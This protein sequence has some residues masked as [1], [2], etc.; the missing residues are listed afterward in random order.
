MT[1]S[2]E[3]YERACGLMP[4]GVNSPVRAFRS[5][6]GTPI[7]FDRASGAHFTDIDGNRYLDLQMSWGPLILGHAHPAVLDAVYAAASRG[8]SF[9]AC[10][11]GEGDLAEA[12]LAGFPG[13]DRVRL[14]NS[15]TEAVMTAVRLA[16][17]ATGRPLIVKFEGGYHGHLDSAL[18]KAGS[19]L[20]TQGIASSAGVP[21]PTAAST[22]VA[23]FDDLPALEDLF[24]EHGA[25]IA[26]VLVEPMPAN[27][28]LLLQTPA[29]LAAVRAL[30]TK[31]GALLIFDE[32]ISG[33]RLHYGGYGGLVGVQPDLVTL[34]KIVGGGMPIGA[35]VGP[36]ATLDLLAPLGP[37]Y[38]AGTLSG[39][40]VSVAAGKATLALLSDPATYA[41]LDLLGAQLAAGLEARGV[42]S[43]RQGS[44]LWP[45]LSS[46]PIPRRAD[47]IDPAIGPRFSALHR[48]LLDL[49]V[50]LPPSAYEVWFLST[51]HTATDV[52]GL[53][54]ALDRAGT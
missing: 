34:G 21:A 31:H 53:L 1:R 43:V 26:A 33:F 4:G 37:V 18:V 38:Q 19:G 25:D 39:N 32:V 30:C 42:A 23:P 14:M 41:H 3:Q 44:I 17:G 48:R 20:V 46:G 11:T 47:L 13:M 16:R 22:L 12:I 45:Y 15:G 2:E 28:G 51:A 54:H 24:T 27:N 35:V 7:F 36:A 10:H 52:D 6:G 40:P 49:G 8:L 9:G 5:V 29:W 50:Y